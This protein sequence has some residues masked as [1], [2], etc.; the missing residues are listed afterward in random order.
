MPKPKPKP[1]P[2][3]RKEEDWKARNK[4]SISS[5]IK[6]VLSSFVLLAAGAQLGRGWATVSSALDAS[7]PSVSTGTGNAVRSTASSV[8]EKCSF[9]ERQMIQR[10]LPTAGHVAYLS[11]CPVSDAWLSEYFE[12]Y[13]ADNNFVFLNFGCNKGYD[14]VRVAAD[15]SRKRDVFDKD[16]WKSHLDIPAPGACGQDTETRSIY[17]LDPSLP[18]RPV[19]IHCVEAV[20]NTAEKLRHAAKMTAAAQNGMHIHNVALAGKPGVGTITFPNTG[21]G[22]EATGLG[23]CAEKPEWKNICTDVPA[24][25]MDEFVAKHVD[26]GKA[27][28]TSR[29]PFI[30]IDVEGYDYTVMKA[31]PRTLQR[32]DYLEF[33]FHNVGDWANQNLRDAI[34]MLEGYGMACYWS[35]KNRLWRISGC[36]VDVYGSFH[37]WSNVACVNPQH[38]PGLAAKMEEVFHATLE[39]TLADTL[40]KIK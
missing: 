15:V 30:A 11:R 5:A 38:Q 12:T 28:S 13:P 23:S 21:A 25:T 29:I 37:D 36:W 35:G 20:P 6:A 17:A 18:K 39:K 2:S 19:E 7:V 24:M 9:L 40:A 3:S 8:I 31:G 34:D 16:K 32:T 33:E 26:H 14:A 10:E 22:Y 4:Y 1:K 27:G